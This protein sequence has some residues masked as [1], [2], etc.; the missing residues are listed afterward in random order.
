MHTDG[1]PEE[2]VAAVLKSGAEDGTLG[3][4]GE[5]KLSIPSTL[6][7]SLLLRYGEGSASHVEL[8]DD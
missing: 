3:G 2:L 6:Q 1:K 4:P 7:G 5:P 8:R